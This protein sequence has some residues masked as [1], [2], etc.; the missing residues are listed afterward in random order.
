M[1]KLDVV[2][3]WKDPLYRSRLSAE[4]LAALPEHPAGFVEIDEEQLRQAGGAPITTA[5]TCTAYTFLNWQACC[6]PQTTAPT[7]TAYT[8]GGLKGC[9][10]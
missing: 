8:F 9:C 10:P 2:R 4:E 7:C 1:N 3:A 5:P 6:P